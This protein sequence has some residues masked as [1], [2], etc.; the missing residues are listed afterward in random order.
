MNLK[1]YYNPNLTES[2]LLEADLLNTPV[3]ILEPFIQK[4]FSKLSGTAT[5]SFQ[6]KGTPLSPKIFGKGIVEDGRM[7]INYL[8]TEYSLIG[9]FSFSEDDIIL[10]DITLSDQFG[11]N[12]S[13]LGRINHGGFRNM[14]IDLIA[15][16]EKVQLLNT[17]ARDNSLF[18]GQGFGTGSISLK[19]PVNNLSIT[20]NAKTDRGTRIFIPIGGLENVDTKDF[21]TFTNFTDSVQIIEQV[22]EDLDL[23]G[24]TLDL[25]ID[26]TNDA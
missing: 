8:M 26:V 3:N 13:L 16:F 7:K 2:L 21:I 25:N 9:E 17:S 5:G 20:A 14:S 12:G 1:G 19:G 4:Y 24:V 23:K 15:D 11:N 6:I 22:L 18:Y 10:D